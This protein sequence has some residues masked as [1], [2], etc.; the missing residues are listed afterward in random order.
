MT[1]PARTARPKPISRPYFSTRTAVARAWALSVM[2]QITPI[3]STCGFAAQPPTSPAV[4]PLL[5]DGR[6]HL[7]ET[8]RAVISRTPQARELVVAFARFHDIA[9]SGRSPCSAEQCA[10]AVGILREDARIGV[11]R[12]LGLA[13]LHQRIRDLL[14]DEKRARVV[15]AVGFAIDI[16]NRLAQ[17]V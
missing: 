5:R 7:G 15:L 10:C 8:V 2:S 6:A 9:E 16:G 17:H 1:G 11:G 13:E 12:I 3:I 4:D 14:V